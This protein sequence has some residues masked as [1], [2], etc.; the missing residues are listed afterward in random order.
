MKTVKKYGPHC[1]QYIDI[2]STHNL[3]ASAATE[4]VSFCSCLVAV[5]QKRR[6][7]LLVL[8]A[9]QGRAGG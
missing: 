4:W 1:S 5:V 7:S 6:R 2:L 8:G 3:T 9:G